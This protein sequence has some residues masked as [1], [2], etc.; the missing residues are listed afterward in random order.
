MDPYTLRVLSAVIID[1]FMVFIMLYHS[2]GRQLRQFFNITCSVFREEVSKFGIY[3]YTFVQ[4]EKR[5]LVKI[6]L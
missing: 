6:V 5:F 4:I 1:D 3:D 2:G